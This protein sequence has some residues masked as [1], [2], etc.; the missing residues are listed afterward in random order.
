MRIVVVVPLL[1]SSRRLRLRSFSQGKRF[2]FLGGT[3]TLTSSADDFFG[4]EARSILN[5]KLLRERP[6]LLLPNLFAM[7]VKRVKL[8]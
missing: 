8:I 6:L 4:G 1:L 2:L 7:V 5:S 3:H